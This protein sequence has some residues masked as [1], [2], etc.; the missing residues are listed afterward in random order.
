MI[1]SDLAIRRP[2]VAAVLAIL[3]TVIGVVGF[4]GLPVREYPDTDPPVVSVS[5]TYTGASAQVIENRITQP[6]ED[7]LAGIDGIDSIASRSQDGRSDITIEFRPGRDVDSAANDVRDRVGGAASTLPEDALAP[8]VRKVDADAQPIMF[9]FVR[10][11]GWDQV[12][13][14]EFAERQVIDRL[15]TVDG[16]AQLNQIGLARPSMRIWL[17]PGRLA[18][19]RLTPR[20]IES[21]LRSQNVELPAGRIEGRSQNLSLRVRRGFTTPAEFRTL[22]VGRGADG[23]LVRLGDVARIEEAAE[24]PYSAFRY[25]GEEGVGIGVV[26]QSGANTLAVAQAIKVAVDQLRKD[27]PPGVEILYGSDSSL[28]IEQA[29]KGVWHTLLEAAVLVTVVIFLFLGSG[30]ATLIP[31]ITVPIC[32]ISTF[33]VLWLLGY[34][35]N[36]LTLLAM[37][38][39]IGLVVDDAIVV[40]ENVHH[41]IEEGEPPLVAAFRGAR[42]V[43]FAVIATT[44]VVCAVFVPVMFLAGQT[45]LLFRELAATM[46]ASVGI[47]GFLA[48]TLAPMLCS[49]LL[50]PTSRE[51]FSAKV[52]AV[53]ERYTQ[54]YARLLDRVLA[55]WKPLAVGVAVL[56]VGSAGLFMTLKSELVPPEDTGLVDI[57]LNAPEGTGYAQLDAWMKQ[58]EK[59]IVP[60]VGK[61]PVRAMNARLPGGFGAGASE[62]FDTANVTIFLKH[63]DERTQTSQDVTRVINR[64]LSQLAALRGNATVRASLAR[65]RGQP[66]S[67]V[68]AGTTYE[69]LAVARDRILAAARD[70]PGILNLDADYIETKPQT[71]I[72]VDR[73]RAGDLGISVDDVSQALQTLMGS[74]RVSTY[75]RDGKE[76]RVIVQADAAER[77]SEEKLGTVYLR[78]RSGALVP[79]SSLV[80][81]RE[82][83]TAKE[84]GR[85]NKL[86]AITLQGGVAP[87]YTLGQALAFL[88]AQAAQSPEVIG[89]GYKGESQSLK[90]TGGSIWIVFG[91]TV[92][93][94]YLL[95][96]A[97]FE[98]FIH[99]A[100]IIS[101]VPLAVAGGVIGLAA[102]GM[103]INLFSQIGLVMLVG[104][105]AKNGV[106]I[107]EYANQLRDEGLAVP[108]AIREASV[109][110]IRPIMMTSLATV[111]GAVPLALSQGAGAGARGAIGMVIVF[112]V[113]IAT[114]VTLFVVP[115][116]YRWLAPYTTSPQA[117]SRRLRALTGG[118]VSEAEPP[119]AEAA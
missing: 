66:I 52:E 15:A 80:T 115:V 22:V 20:D 47:S 41:R 116:L 56:L 67:F 19:F 87:G 45:G 75:V 31:A 44:L 97:Q 71:L 58:V 105:A 90:Q 14:G 8:E 27:L 73:Q 106:L 2:V 111:A 54:H 96:A 48:L 38:L 81:L 39:A 60:L 92:G 13:L 93:V 24:N 76:Y 30:R 29:I 40:L 64:K 118:P 55:N 101:A 21:A 53:L 74:R 109:R 79:L 69:D 102:A 50:R 104:L 57:R 12:R 62:D 43:G 17:D 36:L 98:S 119:L 86:R 18:A 91:L 16:V 100:V 49:K 107:I 89:V 10:A 113:T 61:G 117:V 72:D 112:G 110:R 7:R 11:P 82:S 35:I 34:S 23:Y 88:E 46:I 9:L 6:L 78:A 5:T 3:L 84:L 25:N 83:S 103:T 94:I 42:Q 59:T 99:P 95:L 70:N 114:V 37:V 1:L 108:E 77:T 65:G 51:G 32:L 26:R 68:I 33:A 85:Y 28:F 4:L 63:W